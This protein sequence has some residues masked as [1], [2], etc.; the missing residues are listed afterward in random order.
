MKK[1]TM[2]TVTY[3][4]NCGKKDALWSCIR[5]GKD[6]CYEC[7]DKVAIAYADDVFFN[8][9]GS[10]IFC[11]ECDVEIANNPEG[12]FYQL[13]QAYRNV[14]NLRNKAASFNKQLDKDST[15]ATNCIKYFRKQL[16]IK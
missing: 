10:D 13:R 1:K 16:R 9:S 5:C 8:N 3:C 6:F 7:K 15:E 2:T 4:D 12:K 14:L 11:K